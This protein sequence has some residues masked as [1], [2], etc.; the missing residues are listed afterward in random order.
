MAI[1]TVKDTNCILDPSAAS[2]RRWRGGVNGIPCPGPDNDNSTVVQSTGT[3]RSP[4]ND[5]S[6]MDNTLHSQH[7]TDKGT[8]RGAEKHKGG[9]ERRRNKKNKEDADE[10][11]DK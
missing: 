10:K 4:V 5:R 8:G 11:G 3:R 7:L 2:H 6:E 1:T 9:G